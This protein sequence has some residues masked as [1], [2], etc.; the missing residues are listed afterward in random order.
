MP[1]FNGKPCD[2]CGETGTYLYGLQHFYATEDIKEICSDCQYDVSKQLGKLQDITF[3]QNE[4]WLKK[5]M[6]NLKSKF[7]GE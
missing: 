3:K 2:I 4:H 6:A 7:S 5:F 1:G